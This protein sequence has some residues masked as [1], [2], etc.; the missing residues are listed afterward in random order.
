VPRGWGATAEGPES[1][2]DERRVTSGSDAA[3]DGLL[4]L[5]NWM[6]A[7]PISVF[8][9]EVGVLEAFSQ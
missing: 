3:P 5:A 2:D 6:T 7:R 4:L 9:D 8:V 1:L